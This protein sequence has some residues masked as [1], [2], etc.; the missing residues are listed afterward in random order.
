MTKINKIMLGVSAAVL[1]LLIY[2]LSS[3][4]TPFFIAALLAYMGDPLVNRIKRLKLPRSI[5]VVL[6][7]IMLFTLIF[8]S[9][10]LLIPL[11]AKQITVMFNRLPDLLNWLQQ[12]ALPWL[13]SYLGIKEAI[14]IE[15]IKSVAVQ[16]WKE[17]GFFALFTWRAVSYSSEVILIGLIN[18]IL[19]LVVTFYLLRDWD[20]MLKESREL[21]PRAIEPTVSKLAREC[22]DML[23]AFFRGQLMV[24]LGIGLFYALGLWVV[25]LDLALLIGISAGILTIVPY[26]GFILGLVA[27]CIA[28]FLQFHDTTHLFYILSVFLLGHLLEGM[29]LTPTLVGDRIGLH[30]VAVIFAILAGGQL[31]GFLGVLMALPVAA[32]MMVLL[33]YSKQQYIKSS[34]YSASSK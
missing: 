12:T 2:S 18:L 1:I 31:F 17:A 13:Y 34:L 4:L 16:H 28:A 6:V 25:G 7:F 11:L 22:N 21:L 27:A 3:I 9:L 14:D 30:P 24:M 32:V 29:W 19:I 20:H 33:R 15:A 23:G 5:A 26:L 10:L 8:F